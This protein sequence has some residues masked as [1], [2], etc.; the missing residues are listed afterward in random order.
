MPEAR[1]TS[2]Y[3]AI[4]CTDVVYI[5]Q[6]VN[7]VGC[8]GMMRRSTTVML[9]ILRRQG[10]CAWF[11]T[12]KRVFNSAVVTKG[13]RWYRQMFRPQGSK[14]ALWQAT[15]GRGKEYK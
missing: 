9:K 12:P 3:L 8:A 15:E 11:S 1:F 6:M 4:E 7:G 13:T 10:F 2:R 14:V 5:G